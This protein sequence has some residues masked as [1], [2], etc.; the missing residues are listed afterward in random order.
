[1]ENTLIP[2]ALILLAQAQ[3]QLI[4]MDVH[5]AGFSRLQSAITN[6]QGV[7]SQPNP[8]QSEGARAMAQVTQA[9]VGD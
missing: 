1:M 5:S 4:T 6:L 7:I 2:D 8:S 9:M 3:N